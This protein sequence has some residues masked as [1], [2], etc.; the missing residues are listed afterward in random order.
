MP[1]WSSRLERERV[2][3]ITVRQEIFKNKQYIKSTNR[4][5]FL[6]VISPCAWE[7]RLLLSCHYLWCSHCALPLPL[8]MMLALPSM[9]KMMIVSLSWCLQHWCWWPHCTVDCDACATFSHYIEPMPAELFILM[10]KMMCCL[11]HCQPCCSYKCCSCYLH[12][13]WHLF[14]HHHFPHCHLCTVRNTIIR[15]NTWRAI[16]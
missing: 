7:K 8:H 6:V 10:L 14:F 9:T 12:R 11:C 2:C 3:V 4:R 5:V 13:C 1:K 15:K 16:V